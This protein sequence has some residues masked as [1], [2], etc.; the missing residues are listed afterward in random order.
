MPEIF[1][2]EPGTTIS[3]FRIASK[4]GEGGMGTVYAADDLTLSRRVA[5]KFMSRSLLSHQA[6]PVLQETVEQ[7]FVREAR[8]AASVNHPNVA[9]IYEANF[10]S[11]D[12]F[13]AMEFIDGRT[14][15]HSIEQGDLLAVSDVISLAQQAVAGLSHAWD[16]YKIIHRDIK[17]ANIMLTKANLVKIVDMGLA[18]PITE[19]DDDA[20]TMYD[21]PDLTNVGTPLGTPQY[22][23]PEQAVGQ[24]N[25]DFRTDMFALGVTLYEVLTGRKA[26]Q[27]KTAPMVYMSQVQKQYTQINDLRENVPD[28]LQAVIYR[29]M[30]PKAEDR[31]GSYQELIR[32]LAQVPLGN[33]AGA[34]ALSGHEPSASLPTRIA[35][36]PG[37]RHDEIPQSFYAT[38]TLIKDRYRVLKPIGLGRAGMV[39]HGLD[40]HNKLE[41]AIK[42]LYPGREFPVDRMELVK[43]NYQQLLEMSHRNLVQVRD[44]EEDATTGELFIIME[45]L[46]G[47]NLRQFT[48]QLVT[49][50]KTLNVPGIEPALTTVAHAIDSV[51]KSFKSV[52]WD[53]KPESIFLC[54]G[55][56][57]AKLLDYGIMYPGDDAPEAAQDEHHLLPLATREYMAPEMWE[58]SAPTMASDQYAF[59]AIVYEMLS[60]RVPFWVQAPLGSSEDDCGDDTKTVVESHVREF[61]QLVTETGDVEPIE[62]LSR[63][64]NAALLK[65]LSRDPDD[66]F[67]G[68]EEFIRGLGTGAGV[69]P[70]PG[71]LLAIAAV[72]LLA[73]AAFGVHKLMPKPPPPVNVNR[74]PDAPPLPPDTSDRDQ[75]IDLRDRYENLYTKLISESIAQPQLPPIKE[76]AEAARE[77]LNEGKYVAA[78]EAYRALLVQLKAIDDQVTLAQRRQENLATDAEGLRKQFSDLQVELAEDRLGR[79]LLTNVESIDRTAREA[80]NNEQYEQAIQAYSAGLDQLRGIKQSVAE[81]RVQEAEELKRRVVNREDRYTTERITLAQDAYAASLLEAADAVRDAAIRRKDAGDLE[82][83]VEGLDSALAELDRARQK[84]LDL[85][86]DAQ[87]ETARQR[88][89]A[90]DAKQEYNKLRL[91]LSASP[92]AV[93]LLAPTEDLAQ[94]AVG[95]FLNG[96]FNRSRSLYVEAINGVREVEAQLLRERQEQRETLHREAL[97]QQEHYN[98]RRSVVARLSHTRSRLHVA[99]DYANR[100]A[101]YLSQTDYQVAAEAYQKGLIELEK[102]E[103][104][105][106]QVQEREKGKLKDV[107]DIAKKRFL[108]LRMALANQADAQSMLPGPDK[109]SAKAR[110]LLDSG[111][112]NKSTVAYEEALEMLEDVEQRL[113][114]VRRRESAT[115]RDKLEKARQKLRAFE[116]AAPELSEDIVRLDV[117]MRLAQDAMTREDFLESKDE[118]TQ[119]LKKADAILLRARNRF[120]ARKGH[121]FTVPGVNMDFVWIDSMRVWVA[122]YEVT[123]ADFRQFRATHNSKKA[124][125]ISLDGDRQPVVYITYLDAIA[126]A[127]WIKSTA[128][129]H[130]ELPN[131]YEFRLPKVEEWMKFA[132]CGQD[133]KYPWG[134]SWPPKYGNF[135]NQEVFPTAWRLDGYDDPYPATCT[136]E[137]SGTNEWGLY[138]I[139]GNVWEWT[140]TKKGTKRAV[141]GGAWTEVTE[142]TLAVEV[143]GWAPTDDTFDNIGLR[144]IL[145]PVEF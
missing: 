123:N 89:F 31:F 93:E 48:H 108:E 11:D 100:A 110:D 78:L 5:I 37:M 91:P 143:Q 81:Q 138:G 49:E 82:A 76:G 133:R 85:A 40:T 26:F 130:F 13:I 116:G 32:A 114:E 51:N 109:I 79:G 120:S 106:L 62:G 97:K 9:Q 115:L 135:G 68:C 61:Y 56:N 75:A 52:H 86:K 44:I 3:H 113:H 119:A 124:E 142:K 101:V 17:P 45:L 38:D 70:K 30:E 64:E 84:A 47:C 28:V 12:W 43:R 15:G 98:G 10:D 77:S 122:K 71:K 128:G 65:A 59:A 22:M 55:S 105:A 27:G 7:R 58:R 112:Y 23:A 73:I 14:V 102:V 107:A 129:R 18:K 54:E 132:K 33:A 8:S 136:V 29:M 4:I 137:E 139:A 118:Y 67:P 53:I 2:L 140:T 41:C 95:A 99:D 69:G 42:S 36:Q 144:L 111:E 34:D 21:M 134:D 24:T 16:E 19:D 131:N 92:R 117:V 39:Y 25:I 126:F 145:A 104:E 127:E 87:E 66:R 141:C 125:G 74:V 72:F 6:N 121:N 96:D 50:H 35:T 90:E 88:R 80:F 57:T 60:K 83:A 46:S 94:Q 1:D 63:R 103:K 20:D